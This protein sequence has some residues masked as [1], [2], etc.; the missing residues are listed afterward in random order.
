MARPSVVIPS[1]FINAITIDGING[2]YAQI[3]AK[4]AKNTAQILLLYGHHSSLERMYSTGQYL[5]RFGT[6]TILDMPGFG[7]MDSFYKVGQKP[8]LDNYANYLTKAIP[9]IFG[10]KTQFS[11]VCMS[12][13]FMMFTRALQLDPQLAKQTKKF[14]GFVG[15]LGKSGFRYKPFKH[16]L[17]SSLT[18]LIS[19]PVVTALAKLLLF[20]K[21]LLPIWLKLFYLLNPNYKAAS[22]FKQENVQAMEKDLWLKND[23]R[24][25]F[26]TVYMMLNARLPVTPVNQ[27]V[28]NI[29]VEHDQ[30][31]D[32]QKVAKSMEDIFTSYKPLKANID[33][34][35]PSVVSLEEEV[36][37]L[38]PKSL[39]K[40]LETL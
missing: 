23:L 15:F 22:K 24:T 27:S 17:F 2:R 28:I 9:Q 33:A 39:K 3:P 26:S 7:G 16:S 40:E 35:A 36:A 11:T 6:V 1:E 21:Y 8:N 31:F 14:I 25:H 4:S 5:S 29:M 37:N 18:W 19:L 13:S 38:M 30:Y 20:N 32:H 10:S 34:H 12:L